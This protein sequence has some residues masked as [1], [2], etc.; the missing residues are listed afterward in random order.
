M[1]RLLRGG[2]VRDRVEAAGAVSITVGAF[3]IHPAAGFITAGVA[4]ILGANFGG[5]DA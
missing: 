2:A 5:G 1:D 3:L 4:L